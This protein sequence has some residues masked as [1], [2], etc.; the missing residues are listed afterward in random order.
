MFAD[1][2]TRHRNGYQDL[3]VVLVSLARPPCSTHPFVALQAA[4]PA[5]VRP[6]RSVAAQAK[7][8]KAK[9]LTPRA[10]QLFEELSDESSR[11][12]DLDNIV[13][14]F[15][16]APK[17]LDKVPRLSPAVSKSTNTIAISLLMC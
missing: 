17:F 3:D 1:G 11:V 16:I 6:Q 14:G 2:Y 10:R 15:Y 13:D 4:P 7:T 12:L 5:A 8:R 9:E